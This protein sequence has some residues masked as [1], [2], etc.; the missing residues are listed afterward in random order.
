[1]SSS[2]FSA[3]AGTQI[4]STSVDITRAATGMDF[5]LLLARFVVYC[6]GIC[7]KIVS[8]FSSLLLNDRMATSTVL[9]R[10]FGATKDFF[11][12]TVDYKVTLTTSG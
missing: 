9:A 2:N 3:S 12:S 7:A 5:N 8:W 1:M 11:T 10:R 6:L 4:P